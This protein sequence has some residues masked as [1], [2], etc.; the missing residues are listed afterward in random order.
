MPIT[1]KTAL[2]SFTIYQYVSKPFPPEFQ[3]TGEMTLLPFKFHSYFDGLIG[4]DLLSYLK[5]EIDLHN[6]KLKTPSTTIP[7]WTHNNLTSNVFNICGHTK[8]VLTLPVEAKQ[9]D[10]YI[11][12][13]T[14]NKDLIISGGIYNCQNNTVNFV[15][16]NYS[17]IDQL[18]YI[19]NPIESIPYSTAD[20]IELFSI[21][22]DSHNPK[23][24]EDLFKPFT[25]NASLLKKS[26]EYFHFAKSI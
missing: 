3:T 4:M 7:L 10:F 26:R 16:T 11:D 6:L 20:S 1:L 15:I 25:S 14:I 2:N 22:S 17:E 23:T 9:C 12:S 24:P 8:T 13:I 5:T 21:T 19:E 18:L